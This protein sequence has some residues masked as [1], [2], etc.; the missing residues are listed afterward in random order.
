[1]AALALD[2]DDERVHRGAR[3]IGRKEEAAAL[4]I[5]HDVKRKR[6]V[7]MRVLEQTVVDH[8]L[9]ATAHL[10]ARLE[11]KLDGALELRLMLLQDLGSTQ[12]HRRVRVMA[13]GVHEALALGLIR[14]VGEL[15]ERQSVVVG[16]QQDTG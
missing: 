16:T 13:A 1:M 3:N 12:K 2:L 7:D 4:K 11:H 9:G 6:G 8:K 10:L 14:N 15:G 5:G